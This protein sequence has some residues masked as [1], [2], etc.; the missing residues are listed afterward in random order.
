VQR[1]QS[2]TWLVHFA[3]IDATQTF[4]SN[5]PM[6]DLQELADIQRIRYSDEFS[7]S[8]TEFLY[9]CL[10]KASGRTV[11]AAAI[12]TLRFFQ[13]RFE[14]AQILVPQRFVNIN[15]DAAEDV[16]FYLYV[17]DVFGVRDK[18]TCLVGYVSDGSISKGQRLILQKADGRDIRTQCVEVSSPTSPHIGQGS[19]V[20]VY[21]SSIT[22]GEVSQGDVLKGDC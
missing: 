11:K 15:L 18:G 14:G 19:L 12:Q 9:E 1:K 22:M 21:I 20:H 2:F 16:A 8:D 6:N 17:L 10:S 3:Y 4:L 7:P 13:D 5:N